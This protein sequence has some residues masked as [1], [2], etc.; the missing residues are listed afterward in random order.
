MISR[1][2][3]VTPRSE[4]SR[5]RTACRVDGHIKSRRCLPNAARLSCMRMLHDMQVDCPHAPQ[6]PNG[7]PS[8]ERDRLTAEVASSSICQAL[9]DRNKDS[10]HQACWCEY[11]TQSIGRPTNTPTFHSVENCPMRQSPSPNRGSLYRVLLRHPRALRD[12]ALPAATK[13]RTGFNRPWACWYP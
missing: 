3:D 8:L 5:P 6:T 7:T 2:S 10:C 11:C 1:S 9:C 13:D 4:G 12:P